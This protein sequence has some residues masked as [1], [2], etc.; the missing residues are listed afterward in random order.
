MIDALSRD[1]DEAEARLRTWAEGFADKARQYQDAA[2]RTE[3]IRVAATS[4]GGAVTVTVRADGAVTELG[5]AEHARN[6]P[7]TELSTIILDTMRQAR[8]GIADHVGEVYDDALGDEDPKTR[9]AMLDTLRDR[10]PGAEET[11]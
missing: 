3:E 6:I 1:P 7:L 8:A 10:F 4:P 2:A 9:A 5:F 11:R